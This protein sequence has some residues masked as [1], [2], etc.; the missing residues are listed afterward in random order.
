MP[1]MSSITICITLG[2]VNRT[3]ALDPIDGKTVSEEELLKFI[4]TASDPDSDDLLT[5]NFGDHYS[6]TNKI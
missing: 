2:D 6:V 3:P 5:R 4:V 1:S